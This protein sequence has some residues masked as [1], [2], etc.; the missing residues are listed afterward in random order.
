MLK[1]ITFI[2]CLLLPTVATARWIEDIAIIENVAVGQVSFSHY[3]HL[4]AVGNNC[5]LCHNQL[6]QIDNSKNPPVS[7]AEMQQGKS[8]GGCHNGSKAFAV[9]GD[10]GSCHL[11][12]DINFEVEA[13]NAQFS[14]EIH[15]G[16]YSCSDCHPDLFIPAV[17]RNSRVTM[18]QMAAGKSCGACHDGNTAFSSEADCESC[19]DM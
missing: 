6:F 3:Q 9:S 4:E 12:H 11:T 15:T 1:L 13:G 19:H 10:C 17:G 18:E 5:V 2:L 8:C 16:N 14:H 7:M